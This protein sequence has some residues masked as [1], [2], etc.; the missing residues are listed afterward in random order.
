MSTNICRK[1]KVVVMNTRFDILNHECDY[2]TYVLFEGVMNMFRKVK[3]GGGGGRCL[4]KAAP[5]R[6]RPLNIGYVATSI[7]LSVSHM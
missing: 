3:A 5:H 6:V 2:L 7:S 4:K 1:V